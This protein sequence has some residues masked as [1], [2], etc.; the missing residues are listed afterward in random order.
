MPSGAFARRTAANVSRSPTSGSRRLGPAS[1]TRR[2]EA[3]CRRGQRTGAIERDAMQPDELDGRGLEGPDDRGDGRGVADG[4]PDH[5]EVRQR[6]RGARHREPCV[7]GFEHL[8][9]AE[10]VSDGAGDRQVLGQQR[11]TVQAQRGVVAR[12]GRPPLPVIV[13]PLSVGASATASSSIGGAA[14]SVA[15]PGA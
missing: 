11:Q 6:D 2:P 15:A 3:R 13:A 1:V 9:I 12:L 5:Q 8:A 7:P 14:G 10:R 4:G